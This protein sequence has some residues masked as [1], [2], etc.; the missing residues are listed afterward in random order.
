MAEL[1]PPRGD[2]LLVRA[3]ARG[4][5]IYEC[6]D[7]DSSL[8]WVLKGPEAEL[9]DEQGRV[10]GKHYA[11]PT[12]ESND[13]SKVVGRVVASED[14]SDPSAIP[15]LLLKGELQQGSGVFAKVRSVQRLQTVG[16]RAP[17]DG[18]SA[19]QRMREA[20]VPY[21]ATYYF[22]GEAPSAY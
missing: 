10:L 4:V 2:V 11:G 8:R 13:G 7:R 16:G 12:W 1:T 21:T 14:S 5:Q 9:F 17:R 15:H 22:Y 19:A 6:V 3:F 18:C 20:R